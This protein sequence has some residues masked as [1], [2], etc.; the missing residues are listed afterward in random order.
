MSTISNFSFP[1]FECKLKML[2]VYN[3]INN[4]CDINVILSCYLFMRAVAFHHPKAV[5]R[6]DKRIK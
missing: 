4:I 6:C 2:I 5:N 3:K 1:R